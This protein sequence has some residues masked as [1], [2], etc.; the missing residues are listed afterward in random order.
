MP[1]LVS[2]C[3]RYDHA[4]G[5]ADSGL[6]LPVLA[7]DVLDMGEAMAGGVLDAPSLPAL[8]PLDRGPPLT[9]YGE[10]VGVGVAINN[11]RKVTH[12]QTNE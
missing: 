10:A 9:V 1:L 6:H 11:N 4:L 12:V 2:A 7:D 3:G 8:A 5:E